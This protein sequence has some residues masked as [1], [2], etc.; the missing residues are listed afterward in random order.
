CV[1]DRGRLYAGRHCPAAGRASIRANCSRR[2]AASAGVRRARDGAGSLNKLVRILSLLP[3]RPGEFWDRV[4]AIADTRLGRGHAPHP[5]STT[6]IDEAVA[7]IAQLTGGA[8]DESWHGIVS[9]FEESLLTRRASLERI[10]P[11]P[12]SGCGDV[13]LGRICYFVC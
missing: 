4:V 10:A 7:R 3:R 2:R 12:F 11:Y 8:I 5:Y 9:E 1:S 6:R 13:A